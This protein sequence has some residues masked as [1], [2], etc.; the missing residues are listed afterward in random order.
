[1][2]RGGISGVHRMPPAARVAIAAL[3]KI[4]NEIQTLS[5]RNAPIVSC[6]QCWGEGLARW[7]PCVSN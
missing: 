3:L 2:G 6:R 7:L 5:K 1:M 4:Q